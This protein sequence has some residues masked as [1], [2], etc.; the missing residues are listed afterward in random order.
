MLSLAEQADKD[1]FRVTINSSVN[2]MKPSVDRWTF[3]QARDISL[4]KMFEPG[5]YLIIPRIMSVEDQP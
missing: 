3:L 2:G 4:M 5:H 1:M